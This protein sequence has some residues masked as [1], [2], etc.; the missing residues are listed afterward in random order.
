MERNYHR[1]VMLAVVTYIIFFSIYSILRHC[2]YFSAAY[3][4]GIFVQSLWTTAFGKGLFF[5]TPEW[6]DLNVT[7]HFGVHN[8]PIL[9]LIVPLYLL[10]PTPV[11]L[12][13][14][15]SIALGT[16][17]LTLFKLAKFVLNDDRKAFYMSVIYLMNPLIHGIN[18]MDF[19]PVSLAV[20]FM[21]LLPLYI[22]KR[23]YLKAILVA[24][25]VLSVKEDSGL[26]LISLA[27]LGILVKN[28]GIKT[29]I[30][31]LTES[32]RGF[33]EKNKIEL[34]LLV[35]GL[36][37]ILLSLAIISHFSQD[38]P[39]IGGRLHRY[40]GTIYIDKIVVFTLIS[41]F[42][43]AFIPLL[44]IGYAVAS[45]PLWLELWTSSYKLMLKVGYP[46]PYMLVPMLFVISIYILREIENSSLKI[47]KAPGQEHHFD[48]T[49]KHA[50]GLALVSMIL[51]SPA[52]HLINAPEY[53][54]GV[55][56][57]TLIEIHNKWGG[58]FDV[59]N[60]VTEVVSH[61]DCPIAT[62]GFIFPHLANRNNT[63]VVV[64]YFG[65]EYVPNGSLVLVA[66]S[67]PDYNVT[68]KHLHNYTTF[69]NVSYIL[70]DINEVMLSCYNE[71][72]NNYTNFINCIDKKV[73]N[74][75]NK[76]SGS[77]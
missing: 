70:L 38:Y 54:N 14:L 5:N 22:E 58:Y 43:V 27:I 69:H 77:T 2:S 10:F 61:S 65:F 60:H 36:A 3:D 74:A 71:T 23:S 24:L 7:T 33:M 64:T 55:T 29:A 31:K 35:S 57:S 37:W 17:A 41:L 9:F 44:N 56:I 26:F 19:H 25:I 48:L 68:M 52:F 73:D 62:Q 28:E 1:Y 49:L 34:I 11:L 63:Y 51:F 66:R 46:Y 32:P 12:L 59:L 39:Y 45:L 8:Q 53:V 67:L 47:T 18:R 6:Q 40:D 4:L 72:G 50:L 76:C 13:V 75:I 15:Q 42:S 21:F 30:K 16:G 20:P